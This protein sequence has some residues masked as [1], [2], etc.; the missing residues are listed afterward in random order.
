MK[1]TILSISLVLILIEFVSAGFI[2][3][4]PHNVEQGDLINITLYP[5]SAEMACI[6]VIKQEGGLDSPTFIYFQCDSHCECYFPVS[7]TFNVTQRMIGDYYASVWDESIDDFSRGYFNV[8]KNSCSNLIKDGDESDVD[9]GGG[10]CDKCYDGKNCKANSDCISSYCSF[11]NKCG[12][13]NSIK[14]REK[15]SEKEIFLVS[16]K[17]WKN[18][19]KLVPLTI[20]RENYS[21]IK[22]PVLIYH[23][24]N[25]KFDADSSIYFIND[26]VPTQVTL[27][28]EV[29]RRFEILL[30][31]NRTFGAGLDEKKILKKSFDDYYS[32]WN[33]I[34]DAVISKNDYET[35]LMSAVFA[36]YKNAPLIFEDEIN[37]GVLEKKKVYIIGSVDE[38]IVNKI[39][40]IA[41]ETREYNIENLQKE[42]I[43]LT[44]TDKVIMVNSLDNEIKLNKTFRTK[45]SSK[46][47]E[48][49]SKNSLASP[50]LASER[51][52][53]IIDVKIPESSEN[54][55][56]QESNQSLNNFNQT[57]KLIS[58]RIK[59]LFEK[60]PKYLTIIASPNSIPESVNEGCHE[61]G[62][63]YRTASDPI[64]ADLGNKKL[65]VGRIYGITVSDT[66]S[67]IARDIFYDKIF[68]QLY[69]GNATGLF[70]GH[71]LERYSFNSQKQN[72]AS[73]RSGYNSLCYTGEEKEGCIQKTYVPLSKYSMKQFIL[74][75]NHGYPD[76]WA[77]TLKSSKI[78]KL[79]LSY[80]FSHACSTNNFWEAKEKLM[81][82][83]MLRQGAMAYHGAVGVSYSDNSGS[84][85]LKK[86]TSNNLTLGE[87]NNE[88]SD[89][90]YNYNED[91]LMLGDP[92]FQPG[93]K[94]I[95]WDGVEFYNNS[96]I[97]MEFKPIYNNIT[98]ISVVSEKKNYSPGENI[99][100]KI[101]IKNE[102]N[103]PVESYLEY[104]IF[105]TTEKYISELEREKAFL[106]PN[107]S[108]EI[109]FS[110]EVIDTMPSGDYKF[111]VRLLNTKDKSY[112]EEILFTVNGT[113]KEIDIELKSCED[114]ICDEEWKIFGKNQKIYLDYESSIDSTPNAILIYP[115]G[116]KEIIT[117]PYEF[118]A[119]K[120]GEYILE[121][122]LSKEGY[123]NSEDRLIFYVY[124]K[125]IIKNISEFYCH[126]IKFCLGN[127]IYEN[128]TYYRLVCE[129]SYCYNES[130]INQRFIEECTHE[131]Q[132]GECKKYNDEDFDAVIDNIDKCK[133]TPFGED[134][135]LFGC[136]I[137]QFCIMQ[138]ICGVGCDL[139][140]WKNNEFGKNPHDCI[141]VV[142]EKEG[143]IYPQ[144][145]ALV[146]NSC[147]N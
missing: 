38:T 95:N 54:S 129:D 94:K 98:I 147:G 111:I 110:M 55:N 13:E 104:D 2:T 124:G 37:Y 31:L 64:Y 24:E 8:I 130:F 84:I 123:K 126:I 125:E 69:S 43:N 138:S 81:G 115:D 14:K 80:V 120:E 16:D 68:N 91:Y 71:S 131:C 49:Y 39:K 137:E 59:N 41:N 78:P 11:Q 70:I 116:T 45:K 27:F 99:K 87:L 29:P 26:Y 107:S 12:K 88:L 77:D 145:A 57:K 9:C 48:I 118:L 73:L 19:L 58:E 106:D 136:S 100:I 33:K 60:D 72:N 143:K 133:Q 140:D 10:K 112:K 92:L 66:S 121:A 7:I 141:T 114:E 97:E 135:D 96:I 28:G 65:Q 86:L 34:E 25:N 51:Q 93:F 74:F 79:D 36:S 23:S 128:Q 17:D 67:Y 46:I 53:V 62:V 63:Q 42:Y 144:C 105:S 40:K 83:N 89:E 30:S 139:A 109:N 132:Y 146:G 127:N 3:V 82:S 35:G 113:L 101:K 90:F 85:A 56:C 119:E 4:N 47:K 32:Y 6:G 21:I 18:V 76:E 75:G 5:S 22:F 20:W 50:F 52:E 103:I 102:E 142:V 117:L 44:N 1:K 108:K 61:T 122:N 134:I 15:Y